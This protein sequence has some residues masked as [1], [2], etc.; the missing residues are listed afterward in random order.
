MRSSLISR[1]LFLSAASASLL[2]VGLGG[3]SGGASCGPGGAPAS[4]LLASSSE[5]TLTFGT[6]TSRAGNDCPGADPSVVSLSIEGTQTGGTGLITFC[7]PRP[8]QL[9]DGDRTLGLDPSAADVRIVDLMGTTD[10]C[11]FAIDKTRLPTGTATGAGVCDNGT[12]PAGFA[13]ALD[14]ALSL[15][16]TCGTTVDSVAVTLTG[17]VAISAE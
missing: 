3:C 11:S 2:G 13:L 6:F 7:V 1:S 12:N 4:G 16:R 10:T 5:V 15:R 14:G 8:D 17:T 9:G